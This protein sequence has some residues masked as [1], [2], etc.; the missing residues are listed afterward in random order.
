MLIFFFAENV[1]SIFNYSFGTVI[2]F[3]ESIFFNAW[4]LAFWDVALKG[5]GSVNTKFTIYLL[6]SPRNN[7]PSCILCNTSFH[8]QQVVLHSCNSNE[9]Q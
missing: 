8:L 9:F 3:L 7:A 5:I 2:A 1:N 6:H 4:F